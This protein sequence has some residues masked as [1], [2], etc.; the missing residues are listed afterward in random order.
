MT[1]FPKSLVVAVFSLPFYVKNEK[2]KL[3]LPDFNFPVRTTGGSKWPI[4][5]RKCIGNS[6]IFEI[7][8]FMT[9]ICAWKDQVVYWNID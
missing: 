1:F 6:M 9:N 7:Y 2:S 5:Y 8:P 3:I 4:L